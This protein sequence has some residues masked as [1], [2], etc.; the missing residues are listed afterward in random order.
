MEMGKNNKDRNIRVCLDKNTNGRTIVI[1][2][3]L[4]IDLA[5]NKCLKVIFHATIS[6]LSI[7]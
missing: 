6:M 7:F 5:L 1:L 3:S 4:L 2:L